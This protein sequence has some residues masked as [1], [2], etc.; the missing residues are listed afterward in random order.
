MSES[1]E[2]A[3]IYLVLVDNGLLGLAEHQGLTSYHFGSLAYGVMFK[4]AQWMLEQGHDVDMVTMQSRLNTIGAYKSCT[5]ELLQLGDPMPNRGSFDSYVTDIL[6][7]SIKHRISAI[8]TEMKDIAGSE[9]TNDEI[10]VKF[11]E[12]SA[13]IEGGLQSSTRSVVSI[14]ESIGELINGLEHDELPEFPTGLTRLDDIIGGLSPGGLYVVAG[15]P[16][17]GKS[18]LAVNIAQHWCKNDKSVGLISLEMS[19]EE[20]A[21]RSLASETEIPSEKI[22]KRVLEDSDWDDIREAREKMR[23]W[24]LFINDSGEATLETLVSRIKTLAIQEDL[25][26][27]IVDYLQL[28]NSSRNTQRWE[29]VSRISRSMKN[30]AKSMKV[31]VV[32]LSQLNRKVEERP[33]HRPQLSDL[34]ES[35]SIEQDANVVILIHRKTHYDD[36]GSQSGRPVE[37]ELIVAKNRSGRRGSAF[38]AWHGETT[39]FKDA[40]PQV[41]ISKEAIPAETWEVSSGDDPAEVRGEDGGDNVS[42]DG[43]RDGVPLH[44]DSEGVQKLHVRGASGEVR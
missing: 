4:Q 39:T 31:P 5:S 9:M 33:N 40:H 23:S 1:S 8:A 16:G 18:A 24:K 10:V 6:N 21:L 19:S 12:W 22:K 11:H 35:G 29:E 42:D 34:R 13:E 27:V 32:A 17:L 28:L 44:S 26:L 43:Q 15:R 2:A 25:D 3:V 38:V 14:G 41:G 20:V 37:T 30:L 7:T 36:A